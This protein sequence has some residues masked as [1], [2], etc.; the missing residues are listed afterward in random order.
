MSCFSFAAESPFLVEPVVAVACANAGWAMASEANAASSA[1]FRIC[2][3]SSFDVQLGSVAIA[4]P[5]GERS[6]WRSGQ[7][8]AH[9]VTPVADVEAASD[10]DGRCPREV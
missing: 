9:E 1:N 2:M 4:T 10:Q 5:F 8:D 3:S 7:V 6:G